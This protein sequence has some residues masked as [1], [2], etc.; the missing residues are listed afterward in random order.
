MGQLGQNDVAL[1][2][3]PVQIPG[4]TGSATGHAMTASYG[5]KT[6]GTLWVWGYNTN[7]P[8]GLNNRTSYSSPVQVPGTWV[9][10][11]RAAVQ[12][13]L[14]NEHLALLKNP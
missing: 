9:T 3:S 4:T 1:R 12:S 10:T 8:L 11:A 2:S 13:G 6:D 14:N 5:I 7:G